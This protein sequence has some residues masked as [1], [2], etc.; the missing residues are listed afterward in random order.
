MFSGG[1]EFILHIIRQL[2][3]LEYFFKSIIVDRPRPALSLQRH[4][5]L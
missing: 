3:Y 4:Y 1:N 2:E 5:R